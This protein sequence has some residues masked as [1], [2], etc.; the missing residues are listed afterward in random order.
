MMSTRETPADTM[1]SGWRLET[2]PQWA[3]CGCGLWRS[4]G[5]GRMRR[6]RAPELF[7]ALTRLCGESG[8]QKG[9]RSTSDHLSTPEPALTASTKSRIF[10][11]ID[12][13]RSDQAHVDD[14]DGCGLVPGR[15]D[16]S[17]SL[18]R[19]LCIRAYGLHGIL[20]T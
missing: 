14:A 16:D 20:T 6:S 13:D 15:R 18:P 7:V 17:E 4:P 19:G 2:Y 8:A 11:H 3:M 9:A 12:W 5:L 10:I 1:L